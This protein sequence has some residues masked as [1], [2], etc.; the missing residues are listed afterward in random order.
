MG[1]RRA[2]SPFYAPWNEQLQ[3]PGFAPAPKPFPPT[4]ETVPCT[5]AENLASYGFAG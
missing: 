4:A 3:Q 1:V 5:A 2:L